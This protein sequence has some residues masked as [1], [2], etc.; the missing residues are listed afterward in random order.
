[1]QLK[2][3]LTAVLA[4]AVVVPA[5]AQIGIYIR[6]G[7]P[8]AMNGSRILLAPA[9][10]GPRDTGHLKAATTRG[11]RVIG[12]S[13]LFRAPTGAIRT[14]T[15]NNRAGGC[16]KVIGTMRTTVTRTTVTAATMAMAIA[17]T[18]ITAKTIRTTVATNAR[19]VYSTAD[20]PASPECSH[21][22]TVCQTSAHSP[23]PD[24]F[25]QTFTIQDAQ[26]LRL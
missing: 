3:L 17:K 20:T 1:M 9:T 15:M 2:W 16:M 10:Y 21:V 14:M 22:G 26:V 6:T 13:R 18:M 25:L 8:P 5:S 24:I 11:S 23:S 19:S 12:H 7:P 4:A